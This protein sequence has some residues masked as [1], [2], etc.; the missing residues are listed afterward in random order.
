[1]GGNHYYLNN[2]YSEPLAGAD[3]GISE[4]RSMYAKFIH[5]IV[6]R[7]IWW[8]SALDPNKDPSAEKSHPSRIHAIPPT[9]METLAQ[10]WWN[11]VPT[12]E[13][14]AQHLT[15]VELIAYASLDIAINIYLFLSA[16]APEHEQAHEKWPLWKQSHEFTSNDL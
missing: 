8:L 16:A 4:E 9:V 11:V 12:S 3:A 2:E 6:T 13:T 15:D 10:H 14:L 7:H 5:I 1:M